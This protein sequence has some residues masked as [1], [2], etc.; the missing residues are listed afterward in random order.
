MK[1]YYFLG[2]P[3]LSIRIEENVTKFYI[4]KLPFLSIEK[5]LEIDDNFD[6]C[7]HGDPKYHHRYT[8]KEEADE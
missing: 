5:K 1:N 2:I 3:F 7:H 8:C 6:S 4:L